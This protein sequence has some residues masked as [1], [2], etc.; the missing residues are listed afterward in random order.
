MAH[1]TGRESRRAVPSEGCPLKYGEERVGGRWEV[2]GGGMK[3]LCAR[4][5]TP[6]VHLPIVPLL[7]P[8]PPV[9]MS[10]PSTWMLTFFT[11]PLT[12]TPPSILSSSAQPSPSPP[13]PPSTPPLY[14]PLPSTPPF[15]LI[16]HHSP[17][18]PNPLPLRAQ[19]WKKEGETRGSIARLRKLSDVLPLDG[20]DTATDGAKE[21]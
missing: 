5:K 14:P 10:F 18:L 1:L 19:C 2:G 15:T 6:R 16:F 3:F 13:P 12:R 7:P 17:P 9:R 8:F 21:G 20:G 11:F 4:D